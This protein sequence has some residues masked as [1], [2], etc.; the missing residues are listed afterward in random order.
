MITP[1]ATSTLSEWLT[2][3]ERSHSKAI[4]M[5]LERVKSVATQLALLNPAPYVITVAGTNGKGTTCRLLETAL[6]LAGFKVG[7]YSSPHL[8]RYNE[9]VRINGRE[10]EDTAF[11]HAFDLINQQK[12]VSLTYFEMGTLSALYLFKQA[13]LDIIILEVG[14]G[15]RLDATNI[16]SPNFAVITSIDID[17]ITFLGDDR[18]KIGF[19]KAGI[20]RPNIPLVVG[21]TDCPDSI[22]QVAN[23]LNCQA[24]YTGKDFSYTQIDNQWHWQ[25]KCP[26]LSLQLKGLP[27]GQI[28]LQNASTALAVLNSLPFTF[29]EQVIRQALVQ[30][31]LPGRFQALTRQEI[32]A[33]ADRLHITKTKN[34]PQIILDVGH[35]PHAARYLSQRLTQ[36]KATKIWAI[37]GILQDKDC[38]GIFTPLLAQIDH[39]YLIPLTGERGQ[40][41]EQ[42][43]NALQQTTNQNNSSLSATAMVSMRQAVKQGLEHLSAD[44]ILLIFGS[45]H[46][47]AEFISL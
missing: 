40:S 7:V 16:V 24:M 12:K 46:T 23:Q 6:L 21:E 41:A 39:W 34:L 30:A 45:F 2:F 5:G 8:I 1:T 11:C 44:D 33:I 32:T 47:V 19:E 42:L 9:R 4:D 27:L 14:L 10:L 35:N 3:L 15:G 18:E 28:P 43:F 20:C 13:Q 25:A 31:K 37:C 22:K 29:S 38:D 26:K 17:H 36:T